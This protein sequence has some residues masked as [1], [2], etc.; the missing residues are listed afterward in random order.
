MRLVRTG[1]ISEN[2]PGK[3]LVPWWPATW[4]GK[5]SESLVSK[6]LIHCSEGLT[7][8]PSGHGEREASIQDYFLQ[9]G[10][11]WGSARC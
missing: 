8:T 11:V 1:M 10:R 3:K 9:V 7:E 6:A 5:A 4:P 2:T